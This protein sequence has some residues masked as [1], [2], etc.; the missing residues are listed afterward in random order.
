MNWLGIWRPCPPGSILWRSSSRVTVQQHAKAF[1]KYLPTSFFRPLPS[2][3]LTHPGTAGGARKASGT[4]GE[5]TSQTSQGAGSELTC[6]DWGHRPPPFQMEASEF[7]WN[8][9]RGG[10]HTLRLFMACQS[11]HRPLPHLTTSS[12]LKQQICKL[13]GL[14][15]CEQSFTWVP[16]A[17]WDWRVQY[18]KSSRGE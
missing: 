7:F 2:P 17:H 3:S 11:P 15:S 12:R 4:P 1:F 16:A 10:P 5:S 6:M 9:R 18:G 13:L 8:T 14:Y